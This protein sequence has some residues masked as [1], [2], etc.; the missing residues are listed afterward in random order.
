MLKFEMSTR[1]RPVLAM[2][3]SVVSLITLC[4]SEE[5]QGR[6]G[7]EDMEVAKMHEACISARKSTYA[8][9]Q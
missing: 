5:S 6:G 7:G 2:P 8:P 4:R 3:L 1:Y 9:Q